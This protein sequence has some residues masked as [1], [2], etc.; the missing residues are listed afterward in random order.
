[1]KLKTFWMVFAL[2]TS[3]QAAT[4]ATMAPQLRPVEAHALAAQASAELLSRFHYQNVPLDDAMSIR[5]F[6]RYLKTL[7]PERIYFLQSDIDTFGAVRTLLDDA[8]LQQKLDAPFAIFT[9]YTQ[10]VR[11]RMAGARELLATGF[12]FDKQDSYRY[13]RTDVPWASS[14]AELKEIWRKRVK[15][16]WLRLKLA[17]KDDAAI[18]DTLTKRYE[19]A[20]SHTARSKSDDVFQLFMNAYAESIEPHTSYLGPRASADFAI[21]MKLSLVGIGAVLQERDEYVTI[22]ELAETIARVTGFQGRLD[23]DPSKPDGTPRKLLDVARLKALG[24]E[25]SIGLEEG[26]RDAYAWYQGHAALGTA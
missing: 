24:W 16:D 9:R 19:Q 7:D 18:R 25:A 13:V 26:L 23:F 10:R 5:I 8:I 11:E 12:D 6:D 15:N 2:A 3:A 22:R 17:G 1:M 20:M 21:T 14:E 4:T